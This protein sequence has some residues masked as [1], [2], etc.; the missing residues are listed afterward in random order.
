MK[1]HRMYVCEDAEDGHIVGISLTLRTIAQEVVIKHQME[2][3]GTNQS[4]NC[5]P[6]FIEGESYLEYMEV[7]SST[8]IDSI[9]IKLSTNY[10]SFWGSKKA[11][12][13]SQT[14]RWDFD[15]EWQ[16]VGMSG[17]LSKNGVLSLTPLTYSME[18]AERALG[19]QI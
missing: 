11:D 15:K 19:I 9:V 14:T 17:T 5:T 16:L 7:T 12:D 18:C 8:Y 1:L 4:A 3:L 13:I 10:Y 6:Y 2:T